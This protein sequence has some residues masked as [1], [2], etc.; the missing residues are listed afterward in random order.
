MPNRRAIVGEPALPPRP[1]RGAAGLDVLLDV[2]DEAVALLTEEELAV[3]RPDVGV[4]DLPMIEAL[5]RLGRIPRGADRLGEQVAESTRHGQ[6]R[7]RAANG[8]HRRGAL[9]AVSANAD[10]QGRCAARGRRPALQADEI[11]EDI[12]AR[13]RAPRAEPFM[14]GLRG[15]QRAPV[16][17]SRSHDDLDRL[18]PRERGD[19]RV[20][21]RESQGLRASSHDPE[22]SKGGASHARADV[23]SPRGPQCKTR[24]TPESPLARA[25][26]GRPTPC[27]SDDSVASEA[28]PQISPAER[29]EAGGWPP[30]GGGRM[31]LAQCD[32]DGRAAIRP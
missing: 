20:R 12:E 32:C 25:R 19:V 10:E 14:Q 18:P 24:P 30:V 29:V 13:R 26:C 2:G 15:L 22:G 27:P 4:D 3:P 16:A 9:R 11:G 7:H 31:P 28:R 6:E 23:V 21:C 1:R 8:D 5:E 17:R